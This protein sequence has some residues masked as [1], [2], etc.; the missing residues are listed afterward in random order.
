[1]PGQT[2]G[3]GDAVNFGGSYVAGDFF[4]EKGGG[5]GTNCLVHGEKED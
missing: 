3:G 4:P 1:M 5:D 2:E